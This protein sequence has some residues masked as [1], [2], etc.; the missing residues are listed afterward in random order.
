MWNNKGDFCFIFFKL[1]IMSIMSYRRVMIDEWTAFQNLVHPQ[2][3]IHLASSLEA[4]YKTLHNAF[5]PEAAALPKHENAL[6]TD[7]QNCGDK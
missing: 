7:M 1:S 5:S 4:S 3:N 6:M 2:C